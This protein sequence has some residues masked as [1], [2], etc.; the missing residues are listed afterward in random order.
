MVC[1]TN[2]LPSLLTDE[3]KF[4][5]DLLYRLNTVEVTLPPLRQR[6]DDI[7]LLASHFLESYKNKY[8]KYDLQ[9][10]KRIFNK[11]KRYSWPGN[12]R[13]L[14]HTIERAVIMASSSTIQPTDFILKDTVET[15]KQPLNMEEV[16]KNALINALE[17]HQGNLSEVA[18]ELGLSRPT[19]YRKM[20]KYGI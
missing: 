15:P 7:T 2:A 17:K 19:I 14:Q 1:A 5:Q 6:K 4:R 18:R 9:F 11:L 10:D 12:I 16:E 13:E 3:K 20:K 8:R